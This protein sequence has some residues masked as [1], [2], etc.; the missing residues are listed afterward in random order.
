VVRQWITLSG[1][2]ALGTMLFVSVP[3]EKGEIADCRRIVV[4]RLGGAEK[5][6]NQILGTPENSNPVKSRRNHRPPSEIP[7]QTPAVSEPFLPIN[8]S[9][10]V[11]NELSRFAFV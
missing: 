9:C 4:L 5:I 3:I 6:S 2:G 1:G 10:L 8:H 11:R 7:G